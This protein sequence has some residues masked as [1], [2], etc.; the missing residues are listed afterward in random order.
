MSDGDTVTSR[1]RVVIV[2]SG[3]A[4]IS[5]AWP[6]VEAGIEVLMLDGAGDVALP[7][8][9]TG[10]IGELRRSADQARVMF[11]NQPPFAGPVQD[12]SP[13]MATPLARAVSARYH[14]QLGLTTRG[15]LAFGSL[16]SGGLSNIWGAAAVMFDDNE[17]AQFPC[18]IEDMQDAYRRVT[19]RIGVSTTELATPMRHLLRRHS[20]QDDG[21]VLELVTNAV[22]S[23]PSDGREA[24]TQCG[25]CLWGCERR[26]IYNSAFELSALRRFP[27][28]THRGGHIVRAIVPA[29]DGHALELE[30][31]GRTITAPCVVLAA[32]TIATTALVLRRLGAF[33]R[34]LRLLSNPVAA[35]ACVVPGQFGAALPERSFSLGQ[36]VYHMKLAEGGIATGLLYAADTLPLG[37]I[38]DRL[39]FSRPLALRFARA[40]A[41]ALVL[42]TCYLPGTFSRN[43]LRLQ[44]G[45]AAQL[46][47][48]GEQPPAT[49]AALQIAGRRLARHLRRRGAYMLPGSLTLS[50]PGSDAHYAGTLPMGGEGPFGCSAD[51]ELNTCRNLH[52]VDGACLP[53]LPA[54][55]CTLT[56][57]ANADRIGRALARRYMT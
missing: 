15:F 30:G 41:P 1:P 50:E 31:A 20:S 44:Q 4:G 18:A 32:G 55:H 27:N 53:V 52:I 47:I 21:L 34:D 22:L 38:A 24:C 14:E 40:L 39:P 48:T 36:L 13:K 33:G 56:I 6:L 42:A 11:G 35:L 54:Q 23:I 26:S 8:A 7:P 37:V 16:A 5:A 43:R 19:A 46:V 25:L 10:T 49:R 17:L 2:G 57:M 51:G 29:G 3:P 9:P 45:E 12:R 28:F